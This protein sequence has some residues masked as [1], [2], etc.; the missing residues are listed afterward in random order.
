MFFKGFVLDS[1]KLA[2]PFC[3]LLAGLFSVSPVVAA[4][5]LAERNALDFDQ[6]F[7]AAQQHADFDFSLFEPKAVVPRAQLARS[8]SRYAAYRYAHGFPHNMPATGGKVFVFDPRR[9]Q[10]AVYSPYGQRVRQG[11]AVGGAHWCRDVNR[12]CRT[13]GGVFRVY[14][15]KGVNCI[16]RRYPRPHGGARMPYCHYFKGG[17]AI[18]GAYQLPNFNASHGCIR[19]HPR[20]AEWLYHNYLTVGTVVVV[21]SY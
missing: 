20:M 17:Y 14:A 2:A 9:L 7:A 4:S 10:F 1:V 11:R 21:R 16:S 15:K 6:A 12:S 5:T 13:P 19:V 3:L 18:H 8:G